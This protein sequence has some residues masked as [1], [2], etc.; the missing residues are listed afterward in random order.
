MRV[1]RSLLAVAVGAST[2][3]ASNAPADPTRPEVGQ[4]IPP[5]ADLDEWLRRRESRFDD[6]VPGAEK[7]IL[8]AGAPGERTSLSVV[9]LP[10]FFA[11][12]QETAP[13]AELVAARLSAN[14]FETRL[15]GHGRGAGATGDVSLQ[16]WLA[17]TWEAWEVGT[18]IGDRVVL[19]G[20]STGAPLAA[21]V[22]HRVRAAGADRDRVAATVLLSPNFAPADER[23]NLILRPFGRLILWIVEGRYREWEPENEMQRRYWTTRQ[24]SNALVP[25]METVRLGN[26]TPVEEVSTPM[27]M[28]YTKNDTVISIPAA[29]A[30]YERWGGSPKRLVDLPDAPGH[31][32]A[33][34]IL[35]PH[36]TEPL[37]REIVDFAARLDPA[38]TGADG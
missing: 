37:A 38:D 22:T 16:A 1:G 2:G 23:A 5:R 11:T 26:Q 31:A 33:G 34:Y 35:S 7:R 6:I 10:G 28:V 21:W 29:L 25:M 13:V 4:P 36:T 27:L 18:R 24:R 14:L 19:V 15:T 32:L 17:D 12:R 8:W 20:M 30:L 3:C 9:Y